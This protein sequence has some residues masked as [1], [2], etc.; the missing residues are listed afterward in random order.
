MLKNIKILLLLST[1]LTTSLCANTYEE[2]IYID[3]EEL[4][5]S[6]DAFY[7]HLG[8]NVWIETRTLHR[9]G[10]GLFTFNSSITTLEN[11]PQTDYVKK[12]KCP[13]CYKYWPIGTRCQNP[14]CPSKYY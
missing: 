8:D 2:R 5:T 13:Y 12:W 6:Q 4:K 7:I 14:S 10:S 1:I 11:G 3:E 9:D